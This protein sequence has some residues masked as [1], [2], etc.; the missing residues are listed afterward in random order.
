V[1]TKGDRFRKAR[2]LTGLGQREFA[3][4]IGVSHQTVTNAEKDHRSVRK[5]TVNAWSLV[6]GVPVEWLETGTIPT[7]PDGNPLPWFDSNEQPSGYALAQVIGLP[8]AP[9]L[10]R[11]A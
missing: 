4:R 9:E 2:E 6:T 5:I 10:D 3:E 8:L 11:V 7:G 1:F